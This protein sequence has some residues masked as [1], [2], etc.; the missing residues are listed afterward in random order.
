ML[1]SDITQSLEREKLKEKSKKEGRP[2][3]EI[4]V[5]R[6]FDRFLVAVR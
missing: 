2:E 6:D 5:E 1:G 4:Q 3:Y